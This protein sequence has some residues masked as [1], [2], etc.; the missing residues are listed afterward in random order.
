MLERRHLPDADRLSVLAAAI[1]LAYA[2]ARFVDIPVRELSLQLPGVYMEVQINIRT[3]IAL[4]VAGLTATGADWLLRQHPA[5]HSHSNL[6]HWL[7]PALTAWVI[8]LP[9]YQLPLG[10]QWWASF[11]LGG[12]LLM[13]VLVAEYITIDPEDVRQ[14]VAAAGLTALSFALFLTLTISLRYGGARLFLVLPAVLFAAGMVSL[15]SLHLRLHGVWAFSL[16]GVVALVC[17]Q[18]AAA[19]H[20]LPI[21]PVAFGLAL[22]APAYAL[23]SLMAGLAEGEPVNK[24]LR[25][26]AIILVILLAAAVWL[27]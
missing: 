26:P 15:R 20:Y 17:A 1:L 21:S 9:L 19:L 18:L 3:A 5:V 10:L 16:A 24:A 25:E 6:E 22:I 13:L 12:A 7:L 4:L 11:A 23:T 8:G 14:P 27:R 2:L